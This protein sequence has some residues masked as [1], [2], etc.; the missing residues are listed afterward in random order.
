MK[1]WSTACPD[2]QE[3]IVERRSLIAFDPLFPDEA[4]AALEVFKSLRIVDVPGRPTFGEACEDYVFDF[5]RAIF[6]AYDPETGHRLIEEF[7]LLISK[8]NIKSTLAAGIM[9][10]ALIRNWRHSQELLILAPTQ[11]V[12]DNSFN[13]AAD[14]VDA[15]DE[16]RDLL[17]V[18]RNVRKITHLRTNAVLKVV[19]ADSNTSAGKKAA[20]VLVEELWLFGKKAGAGP[21]LQE[22]TGGLISRPE[23][24]VIYITTQ[25]DEPPAGVFKEKLSYFR[26]VRDGKID[27]PRSLAVLYE[28]P[29]DMVENKAYLQS[30]NFYITN[31]NMGR[32]VRQDW[33]ERK[34]AK[35][36]AGDDEE[37][38]T[39]Q[40]FL[41][42]HLNVEIGM[43]HRANRW[44]GASLWIGGTD[45]DLA[46]L[47]LMG[48]FHEIIRRSECVTVG[49]DGGGLD[50]LFGFSIVGREP[51][52]IEVTIEI[53]GVMRRVSMKR[54]LSCSRAWC[55]EGLLRIRKKI[56]P[57]LLDLKADGSLTI[58]SDGLSDMG[59]IVER[60]NQI[61][62]ANKLG[63]VAVDP[64]GIGDLID[65]LAEID[66]TI[67]NGLL[68][69][70]PQGIGMMNALKTTGR[71]L[72]SGLFKHS[73]GPLMEWC[74][75]NLK[76]EPTAT[77]IRATK[78]TAG[79]AKID[80]AMA[81][82]NAV[83][84]M[85]R[86]PEP[87]KIESLNDFLS[88]PVMVGA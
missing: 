5:V 43:R 58:V 13:P 10:T 47:P 65:A 11:E 60:I 41:A 14:M 32:S 18:Q 81:M 57:K 85:S 53:D 83:T 45:P 4:E 23:G 70:A 54:W 51:G 30:E 59:E 86:N 2:W 88:N 56:A 31:P 42:K 72:K 19:S 29:E 74:V 63:G 35:V 73:G 67:E 37:G 77:A 48:A 3:R 87:F 33:L 44:E 64:A 78:Q 15:D 68:I 38:D 71:R 49:I 34:F 9:L 75:S 28:F 50:D 36:Q 39:I 79:D 26:D 6:G 24:F 20:F 76:I 27:D 84:L 62:Q 80:P 22:A 55:D 61:K 40:S 8:K 66:V 25:S 7:F 17:H 1:Q 69:G 52:E 21:M 12:A 46:S 82:F 16:L